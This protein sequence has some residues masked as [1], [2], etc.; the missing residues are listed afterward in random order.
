MHHADFQSAAGQF[1]LLRA[2]EVIKPAK[3]GEKMFPSSPRR[4][5]EPVFHLKRLRSSSA[6]GL[7]LLLLLLCFSF[8]AQATPPVVEAPSCEGV[9]ANGAL[10]VE[11]ARLVNAQGKPIQLKGMSTHGIHWFPQYADRQAVHQLKT[12]GANLFRVAMYADSSD[13]GY[14]ENKEAAERN[15][16]LL[17][18]AVRHALD[19]DMYA[20]IDWHLLKDETPLRHVENAK[21]FFHDISALYA[22]NPAVI[23]EICNEPNGKTTWEDIRV[24]AEQ[25]IPAIR[26]NSPNA[27]IIVG[28]PDYSSGIDKVLAAPLTFPNIA[29]AYHYYPSLAGKGYIP[30]L[31][32]ALNASIAVFVSEWGI[33]RNRETGELELGKARDFVDFMRRHMIS[34]ANWSLSNKDESFSAIQNQVTKLHGWTDEDLTPSGKLVFEALRA[35]QSS[36][37]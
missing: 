35:S 25:V 4:G 33:D 5:P 6:L 12:L 10:R 21:R 32:E 8:P 15:T 24:Y 13:G 14:N 9:S 30:L 31:E 3:P 20:I 29:Y 28:T 22:E 27:L 19:E 1:A 16:Y 2:V 23:Y 7:A 36:G 17:N 37:H 26:Y 18:L 34:W 11:G